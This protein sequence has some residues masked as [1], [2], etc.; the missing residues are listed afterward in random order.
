MRVL[1]DLHRKAFDFRLNLYRIRPQD[2]DHGAAGGPE[3]GICRVADHGAAA[4]T[5]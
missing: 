5:Q 2:N 3:S 1:H 4:V